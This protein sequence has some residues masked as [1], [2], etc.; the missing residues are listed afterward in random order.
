M[1]KGDLRIAL[2]H[3][4]LTRRGGAEV[5]FEELAAMF[6][7]ADLFTL[8]A[9]R[10]VLRTG[11]RLRP[12]KTSYLQ[13]WPEWMRRHPGRMLPFL[14]HAA[15]Q[16]D[17]SGYGL[18]LSSA[19][20]FA[21][22]IVTR[23]NVPHISYCHT[24]T[25][26]LWDSALEVAAARPY[27]LRLFTKWFQHY[28]RLVDF[29]AAQRVDVFIANSDYTQD[30][31]AKFYRRAS[32][33]IYP[34]IDTEFYT[35]PLR[36]VSDGATG[37]K[38]YFLLVGR[39]TPTKRFDVAIRVCEK[40]ELPLVVVGTGL[41]LTRL[42]KF[43]GKQTRFVGNVSAEELRDF[44]R[45]AQALL[46]PGVEDFG[47]A[48]AEALACGTPV[49]A[50][51]RGGAREM[52]DSGRTGILYNQPQDEALAEALR[53]FIEQPELFNSQTLAASVARFGRARFKEAI[54]K[55][56]EETI[57]SRQTI[58][59]THSTRARAHLNGSRS[60][61]TREEVRAVGKARSNA[62]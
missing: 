3:D 41:D 12:V 18:V 21:K 31:I 34:P 26:Y 28:L 49:I 61:V 50:Y 36:S 5:V 42:K 44:Y 11:E 53:Q 8:Y 6:P 23:S 48:A 19:S 46:Q 62:V 29:T 14:P 37:G 27:V 40:L 25:R 56:V 30:R 10:P 4:E 43:S 47:M 35:P 55:L 22:A 59:G 45:S 58:Y 13:R 24:S 16:F 57:H 20:A 2:L 38:P 54:Y 17:F 60:G 51:G 9:G 7:Q 32:E 39:L 33:V 52:I 15:E 1:L